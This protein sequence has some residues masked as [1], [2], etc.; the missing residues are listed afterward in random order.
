MTSCCV[1]LKAVLTPSFRGKEIKLV[2]MELE[3]LL[4]NHLCL[5]TNNK[6]T[7]GEGREERR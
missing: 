7:E 4:W 2:G 1:T 6:Y 5:K 3:L